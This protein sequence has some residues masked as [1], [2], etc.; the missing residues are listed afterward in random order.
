M[1]IT[2][3]KLKKGDTVAIIAP[4][5]SMNV[6]NHSIIQNIQTYF[7]NHWIEVVFWKSSS[8]DRY[9]NGGTITERVDDLMSV[10]MDDNIQGIIP[11]FG[12]YTANQLLPYLD[13]GIIKSHPKFFMWY[14][15]ITALNIAIF[16]KTWLI[17]YCG[18]WGTQLGHFFPSMYTL[19]YFEKYIFGNNGT[20]EIHPSENRTQWTWRMNVSKDERIW[21]EN[22]EF[23]II[24]SWN[25]QGIAFWWNLSTLSLLAWTPY[26]QI[27]P[28]P[29][30]FIEECG[31]FSEGS[32][33]R[34]LEQ[35]NQIGLFKEAQWII[36]GRF[37]TQSKVRIEYL[38]ECIKNY[39]IPNIPIIV[40]ADFW[41]TEP[42]FTIPI[43]AEVQIDTSKRSILVLSQ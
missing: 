4:S 20:I 23:E 1:S 27:P 12:W 36:F 34:M 41:H 30:L 8:H 17:T 18:P 25:G 15:D 13:Y 10:F 5:G 28:N 31:E 19:H 42:M 14:S 6:V 35:M 29:I 9:G 40:N 32:I 38:I 2:S 24:V 37:E 39:V 33:I 11:I 26:I 16:S 22:K 43:W 3:Q 21:K 7:W